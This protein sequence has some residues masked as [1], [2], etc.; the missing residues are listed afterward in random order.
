MTVA[1]TPSPRLC[2]KAE[3]NADG[4]CLRYV[5]GGCASCVKANA[6]RWQKAHP[7]AVAATQRR[8]AQAHRQPL[9]SPLRRFEA[10]LDKQP[11][12]SGCWL[13]TGYLD[14]SG[15]G[16]FNAGK[17]KTVMAHRWAWLTWVGSIPSR[18]Y[19]I[20]QRCKDHRCCQP[21]HLRMVLQ[22]A[23]IGGHLRGNAHPSSKLSEA[24][25]VAIRADLRRG[26]KGQDIAEAF[27]V[28]V[29]QVSK[30]RSGQARRNR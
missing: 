9:R 11:G 3:H 17:G 21:R 30:I 13:W 5:S 28:S 10:F 24:D 22:S 23:T 25:V 12:P 26:R 14:A 1:P 7:S 16:S 15:R 4:A 2:S 6:R 8:Y 29:S 18:A 20:V 19:A 27:G